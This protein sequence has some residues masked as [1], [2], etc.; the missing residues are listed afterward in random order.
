M[1]PPIPKRDPKIITQLGRTR[2]DN[3]AW[4]KDEN[5]Q[6]VLRDPSVLR[7]DIA[8]YL[9]EENAYAESVLADVEPLRAELLKEMIGRVPPADSSV[10]WPDGPWEYYSRFEEGAQHPLHARKPRAGGAE[11]ILLD[12]DALAKQHEYY[13]LAAVRHSDDHKLYVYAEDV[14]GSEV[15]RIQVKDL[16]TGELCA[17]AVESTAG[18][19]VL[20]PDSQWLFWVYRDENGRPS[21]IYRRPLLGGED[22]LVFDEPDAGFFL[23]I[24]V[25]ASKKWIVIERGDHDTNETLLIPAADPCAA[26]K[27]AAP[28]VRGE[29]YSFTHWND[30]FIVLT[31]AGGAVDFQLMQTPD[32]ATDRVNW[33]PFVPYKAGHY[34]LGASASAG[35]LA[36]AERQDGNVQ[37]R[38]VP[39]DVTG[40]IRTQAASIAM[41][42]AA[43][44]LT[45]LGAL[46]YRGS[47]LRYIYESPT[48]PAHWYDYDMKTGERVLRKVRDVPSGH[49][50]AQYETRRLFATAPDGESVP[51]TVLMRR[52]AALDGSAPLLLYGYGSYGIAMDA[53]FST[54]VLSLV[55][56]GWIYA[57]AHIRGGSEKG[58]NWFLEGRGTKKPNT[59]TDFIACGRYLAANGYGA[60]GRIVAH[61]GSAGGL[62]MGA[63][64]NMAPELFAGIAAQVPFVDMR[65]TMSD[66]SLPL[67]PPEWP[68]WGNPLED[69]TAY[70]LIASYSPYDN[71]EAKEYPP[72]LAMGGLSDP[73]VTYWE[74]AK[75][76]AKLREVAKGGPFLCRINM[77]AGHGGSSGRFKRLEEVALVQAF[78]IWAM[79]RK[80]LLRVGVE[81]GAERG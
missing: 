48:T 3:Y 46:E 51:I 8:A 16:E 18:S 69:P 79:G 44:D 68:E 67:T 43:F 52:G 81:R 38:I 61:G 19:F 42:E 39:H 14:Q 17:P 74:P 34:I 71:I 24:G 73:R 12:V 66:V 21:R 75:W 27:V 11:Q 70:D 72:I 2:T 58:W 49:D 55:D 30:R 40:D 20:S 62:L 63:V 60:E 35:Y 29:R 31:N 9:K 59:F 28:L 41:D 54:S 78:A 13:A 1:Q 25:S 5:W 45:M 7:P 37:I 65:N 6:Q 53:S 56:R 47:V 64:A 26:P 4:M 36:W 23:H 77:G 80:S 32:T 57:I 50:P 33:T 76:I 10:P 22:V 15:Y